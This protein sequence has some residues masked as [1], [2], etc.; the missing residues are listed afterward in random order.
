MTNNSDG[1]F[2]NVD[3]LEFDE[4]L[5][6]ELRYEFVKVHN[7]YYE[8]IC[9]NLDKRDFETAQRLTHT[10]KSSAGLIHELVLAKL[11]EDLESQIIEGNS[12]NKDTLIAFK[13]EFDRVI[14]EIGVKERVLLTACELLGKDESLELLDIVEPL[15][16]RQ[17]GESLKM[18]DR[19]RKIPGSEEL[20]ENLDAYDFD[21][22]ISEL[23]RLR[24][25][26]SL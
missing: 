17:S 6:R 23:M 18:L 3:D 11:S 9:E 4:Q 5:K 1:I 22:A 20:C 2:E 14:T 7:N 12:P 24:E 8:Q 25:I 16:I 26:L 15:I 21:N 19:L 13:N 10:I